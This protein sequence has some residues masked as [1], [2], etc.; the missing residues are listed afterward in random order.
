MRLT[1]PK[2]M[3]F[4]ISLLVAVV[5]FVI[6]ALTYFGVFSLAWLSLVGVLLLVAAF[7]LLNLGLTLKG[8]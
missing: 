5:G 6:Y 4:W 7:I 1:P 8:L 3:T 2:K